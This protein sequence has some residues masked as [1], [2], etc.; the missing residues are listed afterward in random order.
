MTPLLARPS[1]R[2]PAASCLLALL[3]RLPLHAASGGYRSSPSAAR[4]LIFFHDSFWGRDFVHRNY[5]FQVGNKPAKSVSP[6]P[7]ALPAPPH[8][9]RAAGLRRVLRH[10]L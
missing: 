5:S 9:R 4:P 8:H 7:P 1:S 6:R 10:H 2:L 3:L